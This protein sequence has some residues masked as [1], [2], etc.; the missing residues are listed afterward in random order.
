MH[1]TAASMWALTKFSYLSFKVS[2]SGNSCSASNLLLSVMVYLSLILLLLS[3]DW[4][5][6]AVV[7][8]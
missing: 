1:S 8:V 3:K 5:L 6:C 2:D 4:S 7:V